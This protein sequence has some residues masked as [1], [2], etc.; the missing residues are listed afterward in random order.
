MLAPKLGVILI[1]FHFL[2]TKK[3]SM[4]RLIIRQKQD[5]V[6]LFDKGIIDEQKILINYV[7]KVGE[8]IRKH[9]NITQNYTYNLENTGDEDV[10]LFGR[11]YAKNEGDG[12]RESFTLQNAQI[13][14][15]PKFSRKTLEFSATDDQGYFFRGQ[16]IAARGRIEQ[17][18]FRPTKIYVDSRVSHP[19]EMTSIVPTKVLFVNGPYFKTS[20]DE[21]SEINE[22]VSAIGADLVVYLGPFIP[23]DS[24]L[25]I[26]PQT[27]LTAEDAMK[28]VFDKL[29]NGLREVIF[30]SNIKDCI[31]VPVVPVPPMAEDGLNYQVVGDPVFFECGPAGFF[32]TSLDIFFTMS[33]QSAGITKGRPLQILKSL[34]CQHSICPVNAAIVQVDHIDAV[35]PVTEPHFYVSPSLAGDTDINEFDF[36]LERDTLDDPEEEKKLVEVEEQDKEKRLKTNEYTTALKFKYMALVTLEESDGKVERKIEYI[37]RP[38][39]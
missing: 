15:I 18:R 30:V 38:K 32:V 39:K 8:N 10:F 36:P 4:A 19:Q 21:V 23:E 25:L 22:Q 35:C 31:S 27:T 33:Q 12:Q 6:Y 2:E 13:Q 29:S 16:I 1:I 5:N 7:S 3:L 24:P 20:F 37:Q 34:I 14:L 26:G 28:L 9:N 17:G 11:L